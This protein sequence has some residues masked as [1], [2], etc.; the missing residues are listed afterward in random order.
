MP[1][2]MDPKSCLFD[3]HAHLLDKRFSSDV[4]D[5]IKKICRVICIYSPG[6]NRDLFKELLQKDHIW[7]TA[8]IHPH[9]AKDMDLLWY[10]LE[11]SLKLD[12]IVA[13]GEIGLDFYYDNSPRNIQKDAFQKQLQLA[14][15]KGLPVIVHSREAFEDTMEILSASAVTDILFHCFSGDLSQ[16]MRCIDN[17]YYIAVG[18]VVTFPNAR[19]LKDVVKK[20]PADRLLFETDCPYLAPQPF[21]GKR[22]EPSY[23]EYVAAEAARLREM[24]YDTIVQIVYENTCR[25][26]RIGSENV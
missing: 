11:G 26:F 25:F 21:R 13:V 22:N 20:V 3:S 5:I 16:M 2:S 10:D 1:S 14:C 19:S 9:E 12:G 17:G 18:G 6:E 7:G 24:D 15:D 8:G 23:I 4:E